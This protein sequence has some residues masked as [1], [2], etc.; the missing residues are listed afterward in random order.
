M[1]DDH[2]EEQISESQQKLNRRVFVQYSAS[3]AASTSAICGIALKSDAIAAEIREAFRGRDG[4][5]PYPY[6]P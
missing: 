6:W 2:N 3:I 1:N 5:M 4:G